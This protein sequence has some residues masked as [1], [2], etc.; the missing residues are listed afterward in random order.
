MPTLTAPWLVPIT[1]APSVPVTSS[2]TKVEAQTHPGLAPTRIRLRQTTAPKDM[3]A[4]KSARAAGR[5]AAKIRRREA[6]SAKN[7]RKAAAAAK[8]GEKDRKLAMSLL[9]KAVAMRYSDNDDV[10]WWGWD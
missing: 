4:S 7:A 6:L 9:G 10:E 8:K 1:P 5:A 2:E 3:R